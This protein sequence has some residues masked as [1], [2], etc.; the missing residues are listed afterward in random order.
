[1]T[2][3]VVYKPNSKSTDEFKIIVNNEEVTHLFAMILSQLVILNGGM[4]RVVQEVAS[5][6]EGRMERWR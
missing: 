6:A 1:M 4:R 5:W 2:T 3:E